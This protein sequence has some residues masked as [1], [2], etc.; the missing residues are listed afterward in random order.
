[1]G[2][3]TK[4][5]LYTYIRQHGTRATPD[6]PGQETAGSDKS[7]LED[8]TEATKK[9]PTIIDYGRSLRLSA[10]ISIIPDCKYVI[11]A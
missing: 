3:S 9:K 8:E 6:E 5:D 2:N 10:F 4:G 7:D 11:Y 1:M